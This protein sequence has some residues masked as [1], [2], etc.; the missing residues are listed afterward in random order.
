MKRFFLMIFAPVDIW[1]T[2]F[3]GSID[4]NIR[5]HAIQLLRN[6]LWMSNINVRRCSVGKQCEKLLSHVASGSE[7]ENVHRE[8][9]QEQRYLL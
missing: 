2:G 3:A 7:E 4:H 6:G 5:F 1:P 8:M 9:L